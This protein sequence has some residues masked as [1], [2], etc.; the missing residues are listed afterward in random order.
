ML[1]AKAR[2]CF[3]HDYV[4]TFNGRPLGG[5]HGQWFSE[6]LTIYLMGRRDLELRKLSMFGSEFALVDTA[7]GAQLGVAKK[8]GFFSCKWKLQLSIGET[9]LVPTFFYPNRFKIVLAGQEIGET[10]KHW[11]YNRWK[12]A[13]NRDIP[14]LDQLLL[15]LI[16]QVVINRQ[17][18]AS[19]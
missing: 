16:F 1:E 11:F 9:L 8:A 15:G 13:S 19:D 17:V 5:F 2:G 14:I 10:R 3:G 18:A 7:D 12:V 6:S 4:I